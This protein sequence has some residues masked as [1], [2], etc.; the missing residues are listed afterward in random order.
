[1]DY[2]IRPKQTLS[3]FLNHKILIVP[4]IHWIKQNKVLMVVTNDRGAIIAIKY[5]LYYFIISNK[6][7]WY[8][9][10]LNLNL[11]YLSQS[12]WIIKDC[13]NKDN[14]FGIISYFYIN[15][16]ND[17]NYNQ[18]TKIIF[19]II[20]KKMY[21]NKIMPPISPISSIFSLLT[22]IL[23]FINKYPFKILIIVLK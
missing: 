16:S 20:N 9:Y 4:L 12:L 15:L 6:I 21:S 7:F 22:Q 19:H 23:T 3:I 8:W 18:N 2:S 1:M 11:L 5:N 13:H 17:Q 14:L 10:W